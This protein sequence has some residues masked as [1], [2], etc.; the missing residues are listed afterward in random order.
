MAMELM[1]E[2]CTSAYPGRVVK[3]VLAL[4][5]LRGIVLGD[6][7]GRVQVTAETRTPDAGPAHALEVAL[8]IV[9][10]AT[11]QRPHYRATVLLD[12]QPAAAPAAGPGPAGLQPLP[13]SVDAAYEQWLFH[14]ACFRGITEIRG[15]GTD[16]IAGVLRSVAPDVCLAAAHGPAWLLDP[17]VVDA[18]LQLVILWERHHH[19]MTPLPMRID[20]F[21]RFGSLSDGP[22]HCTVRCRTEGDGEILSADITYA[23]PSGRLL[24]V[25][26]GLQCTCTRALNR[27][28]GVPDTGSRTTAS[29]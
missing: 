11:P 7:P 8:Q 2:V 12:A 25:L 1:A 28:A 29:N 22:V 20:R 19:D 18:S 6:G 16:T 5:V 4:Q 15:I 3:E 9:D 23:D 14:G 21:A 13:L 17:V 24:A 26:E 27:L 10:A